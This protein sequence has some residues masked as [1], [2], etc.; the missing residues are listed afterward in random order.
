MAAAPPSIPGHPLWA[1][2]RPA[3]DCAAGDHLTSRQAY[4]HFLWIRIQ[5]QEGKNNKLH[6]FLFAGVRGFSWCLEVCLWVLEI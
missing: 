3:Q 5:V 1:V 4:K 2:H 6:A